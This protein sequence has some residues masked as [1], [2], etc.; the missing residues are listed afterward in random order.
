MSGITFKDY[1]STSFSASGKLFLSNS[2]DLN[3][4]DFKVSAETFPDFVMQMINLGIEIQSY[5]TDAHI[6]VRFVSLD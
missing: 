3:M 1:M 4:I 2:D 5:E 6:R